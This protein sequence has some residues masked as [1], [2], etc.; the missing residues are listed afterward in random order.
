MESPS[1]SD[2]LI[3]PNLSSSSVNS[4]SKNTALL[5]SAVADPLSS[6]M[7]ILPNLLLILL[8]KSSDVFGEIMLYLLRA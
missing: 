8:N 5:G 2:M 4:K 6:P 1:A 7:V 3:L